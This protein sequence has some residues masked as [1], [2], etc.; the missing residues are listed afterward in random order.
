MLEQEYVVLVDEKDKPIGREEKLQ[1]HKKGLLH[2][3]F[4]VQITDKRGYWLLQQRAQSKYH[5]PG[6]WANTCCSHPGQNENITSAA[7]RRLREEM[8]FD[9]PLV[10]ERFVFQYRAEL[11]S[12]LIENEID[13]VLFGAYNGNME[14]IHP[15][16]REVMG[17]RWIRPEDMVEDIKLCPEIYAPW[18]R[19]IVN[20]AQKRRIIL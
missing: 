7:R 3:A 11:P 19:T 12:G 9:V 1:A 6:L 16:P 18:F 5:C 15:N 4:S 2:R 14:N 13:H 17:H 8:G 10:S 20:E